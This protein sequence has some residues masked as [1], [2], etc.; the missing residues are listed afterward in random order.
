MGRIKP[1]K[2]S[3]WELGVNGVLAGSGEEGHVHV[4]LGEHVQ[5]TAA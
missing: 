4:L 1:L 5:N 3:G 2:T